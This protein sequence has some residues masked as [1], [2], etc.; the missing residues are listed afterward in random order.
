[1]ISI[2]GTYRT[3]SA[4][5][6]SFLFKTGRVTVYSELKAK[7]GPKLIFGSALWAGVLKI[8]WFWESEQ[9]FFLFFFFNLK[10]NRLLTEEGQSVIVRST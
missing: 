1:M 3:V 7:H 4:P 2:N 6:H 5:S 10:D 8:M 9:V